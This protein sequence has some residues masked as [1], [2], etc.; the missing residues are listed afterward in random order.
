MSNSTIIR[1]ARI[2]NEGKI[3]VKDVYIKNGII[4][5]IDAEIDVD[6]KMYRLKLMRR[7][8]I[9]FRVQLMTRFILESPDLTQKAEIYTE[10]KGS[11]CR[12]YYFVYGDAQ[13]RTSGC[14]ARI[15]AR[16]I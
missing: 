2:V 8:C 7:A 9:C 4:A 1:E 13:Y 3:E 10:A 16:Q 12:R 6:E 11:G 14:Y 5:K 15:T